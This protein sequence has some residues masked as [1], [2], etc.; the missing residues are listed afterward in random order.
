VGK[1]YLD[2]YESPTYIN[3]FTIVAEWDQLTKTTLRLLK[4]S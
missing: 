4:I 1:V 2:E 3:L